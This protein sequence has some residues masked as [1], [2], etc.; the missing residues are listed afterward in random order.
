MDNFRRSNLTVIHGG[1]TN[2]QLWRMIQISISSLDVWRRAI[3]SHECTMKELHQLI[4]ISMNWKGNLRFRFYCE[5]ADGGKQYL[6]DKIKLGDIDFHGKKELVYE[7]GPKWNIKVI[8]MSSYQGSNNEVTRFVAGDGAAPPETV[9]GPR[10]FNRI[11]AYLES[12]SAVEKQSAL[13][14]LGSD[15]TQGLFDLEKVNR[16]LREIRPES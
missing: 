6:H 3:I 13:R 10:H 9:E 15:F 8:I 12:G 7:Y 4:Q 2:G 5:T 11:L 14:E 1:K 16:R